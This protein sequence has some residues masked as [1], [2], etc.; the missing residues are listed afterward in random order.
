M[1]IPL[2][3]P[4]TAL[5]DIIPY[6]PGKPISETQREYGLKNVIKLAS[7]ENH[8]GPAPSALKALREGIES[9]H[10][11]PD[12]AGYELKQALS[13][14]TGFNLEEIVL[15]NG[16]TEIVELVCEAFLDANEKAITGWPAFFKYR[17]AIR[18][19]RG[20]PI[21]IPLKNQAHDLDRMFDT[22]DMSTK[23]IFIADPNNPTGT[24]VDKNQLEEFVRHTAVEHIVVLDQAYYEF[25]APEKRLDVKSL[26]RE[27][28]NLIV[29][30]TFSKIYGLAG[31]RVGYGFARPELISAMN[32]VREAFN[33]NSLA[34]IAA[35]K[36]LNDAEFVQDTLEMN[37]IGLEML[38][39]GF[40]RLNLP[41]VRS[42]TNFVLVDFLR[43]GNWVFTELLKR[44]VIIRPMTG[45]DMPT[46]ARVSTSFKEDLEYFLEQLEVVLKMN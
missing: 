6:Q 43:D 3:P 10:L 23:I 29:L 22:V 16:S 17:I 18:I 5:N 42:E 2:V 41:Y 14:H 13:K 37:R 25:I 38:Y 1:K 19:M 27:G 9:V 11:Y 24:M 31:L 39:S 21:Q 4:R 28:Y 35:A 46:C 40:Q 8:L 30:R 44:G 36:A 12:G 26:I 34:Q 33:C 20:I 7:N 32:R 15:G 45:Y